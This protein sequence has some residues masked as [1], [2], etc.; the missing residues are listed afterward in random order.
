M[1]EDLRT[2]ASFPNPFLAH[3]VRG[4]LEAEG[5][6]AHVANDVIF[7]ANPG[8]AWADGGVKVRVRES[9][10]PRALEIIE[11]AQNNLGA[12]V[13]EDESS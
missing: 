3:I 10:A 4:R 5:I 8:H 6:E 2:V 13:E 9:D 11:D 1:Y 7:N 12:S